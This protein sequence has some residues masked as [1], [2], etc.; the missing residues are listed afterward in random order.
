VEVFLC[1]N[2]VVVLVEGELVESRVHGAFPEVLSVEDRGSRVGFR[3]HFRGNPFEFIKIV[4]VRKHIMRCC[5][6]HPTFSRFERTSD[7]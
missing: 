5:L 3:A 6:R 2:G 4:G 1:E 7:L